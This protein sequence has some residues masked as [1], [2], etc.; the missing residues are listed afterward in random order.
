MAIIP[1]IGTVGHGIKSIVDASKKD[2]STEITDATNTVER[3]KRINGIDYTFNIKDYS[4]KD[5][6]VTRREM[7]QVIDYVL[8]YGTLPTK[9]SSLSTFASDKE[10]KK[11]TDLFSVML[12]DMGLNIDDI[13][14]DIVSNGGTLQVDNSDNQS[15][16]DS[17]YANNTTVND[18]GTRTLNPVNTEDSQSSAFNNYY[19]DLLKKDINGSL[20]QEAY[21]NLYQ[22]E[23]NSANNALDLANAQQQQLGMAQANTVKNIVD[24]LR[25]E[26]MSKLRSG[27]SESQIASENMQMMMQ[28]TNALNQQL[29]QTDMAR[30]QAQQQ[31]NDAQT[32]AYNQWLQTMGGLLSSASGMAASDAGDIDMVARKIQANNPSMSYQQALQMAQGQQK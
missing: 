2:H 22:T 13:R 19:N 7:N 18:D 30:L 10:V 1:I 5:K 9:A 25:N 3:V 21:N 6:G 11:A 24:S 17:W 12:K 16:I 28:N 26:R 23:L 15:I 14:R 8:K 27:M 32:N 29:A 4:R 20:G 31:A